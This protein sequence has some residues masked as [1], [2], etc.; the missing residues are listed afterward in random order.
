MTNKSFTLSFFHVHFV[1]HHL[2]QLDFAPSFIANKAGFIIYFDAT[3]STLLLVEGYILWL[4]AFESTNEDL[5]A[6]VRKNYLVLVRT[7]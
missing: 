5:R 1:W 6:L 7:C 3:S 4:E 2:R